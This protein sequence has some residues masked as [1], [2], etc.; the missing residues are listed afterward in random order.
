M[1]AEGNRKRADTRQ[2]AI[3][4]EKV[5]HKSPTILLSFFFLF[6]QH[7]DLFFFYFLFFIS[8]PGHL[9]PGVIHFPITSALNWNLS[10][11]VSCWRV[12]HLRLL[13]HARLTLVCARTLGCVV[14]KAPRSGEQT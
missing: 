10:F 11:Q 7:L 3:S 12:L 14:A 13:L 5:K 2:T 4:E 1:E 8:E 9:S 6:G